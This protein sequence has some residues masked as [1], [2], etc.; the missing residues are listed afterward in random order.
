MQNPLPAEAPHNL[1]DANI[2]KGD[3]YDVYTPLYIEG[4]Y[5]IVR[6]N[7]RYKT[8]GRYG[9]WHYNKEGKICCVTLTQS[10]GCGAIPEKILTLFRML[11]L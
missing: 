8:H 2:M 7:V 9:I 1:P 3:K 11:T 4:D 5:H 10:P 6:Y